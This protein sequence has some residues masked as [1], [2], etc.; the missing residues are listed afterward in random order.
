MQN[1]IEV[2]RKKLRAAKREK[3]NNDWKKYNSILHLYQAC[4]KKCCPNDED[5]CKTVLAF[6]LDH[7]RV[8]EDC[9]PSILVFIDDEPLCEL[10]KKE[11]ESLGQLPL[12]IEGEFN[13]GGGISNSPA[14]TAVPVL[15]VP[16]GEMKGRIGVGTDSEL[17][18]I[19]EHQNDV[20]RYRF[21]PTAA[22]IDKLIVYHDGR[23]K[24]CEIMND[25]AFVSVT[26]GKPLPLPCTPLPKDKLVASVN[27]SN[28]KEISKLEGELQRLGQNLKS[29]ESNSHERHAADREHPVR[30]RDKGVIQSNINETTAKLLGLRGK[31]TEM[32]ETINKYS[33]DIKERRE[34]R[35]VL[36]RKFNHELEEL[37]N[38]NLEPIG[39]EGQIHLN[40]EKEELQL[41][42]KTAKGNSAGWKHAGS[43]S[44]SKNAFVTLAFLLAIGEQLNCPFQILDEIDVFSDPEISKQMWGLIVSEERERERERERHTC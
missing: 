38:G 29:L 16:D 35:L 27:D 28:K 11:V 36:E 9:Q 30:T 22:P 26:I 8:E 19:I 32:K 40:S 21:H 24:R 37:F 14:G 39:A 18:N 5:T 44:G 15:S 20:G 23:P 7:Y 43:L 10:F 12:R 3:K 13:K 41:T 34:K 33:K 25:G 6:L 31:I 1:Q 2:L 4:S 42:V 17:F